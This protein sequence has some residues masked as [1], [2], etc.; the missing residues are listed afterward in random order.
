MAFA[1]QGI[2][3]KN[4]Y[5]VTDAPP[6][7]AHV[8]AKSSGTGDLGQPHRPVVLSRK[9]AETLTAMEALFSSAAAKRTSV[10]GPGRHSADLGRR[11]PA[12][13]ASLN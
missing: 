10:L 6:H 2:E 13:R 1:H 11:P 5:G 4:P 8:A 12:A 9:S 7:P 3:L